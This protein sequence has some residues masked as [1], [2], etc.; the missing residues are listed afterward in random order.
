MR[1]C[2]LHSIH[3]VITPHILQQTIIHGGLVSCFEAGSK[4]TLE[5]KGNINV[6]EL[7]DSGQAHQTAHSWPLF[8]VPNTHQRL[9]Q[10]LGKACYQQP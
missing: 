2:M 10:R 5:A 3:I 4:R 7:Q 6:T 8:A 9:Q 1:T